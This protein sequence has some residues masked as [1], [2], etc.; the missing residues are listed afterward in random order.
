MHYLIEMKTF[1]CA[2]SIAISFAVAAPFYSNNAN[3]AGSS[4]LNSVKLLA[5]SL[6]AIKD[7]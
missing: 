7:L 6:T 2:T 4:L 5:L 3:V 1:I